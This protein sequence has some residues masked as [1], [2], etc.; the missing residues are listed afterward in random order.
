[1]DLVLKIPSGQGLGARSEYGKR[2]SDGPSDVPAKCR[3]REQCQQSGNRNDDEEALASLLGIFGGL[4]PLLKRLLVDSPHQRRT[5]FD[6]GGDLDRC[7]EL[8]G[9]PFPP[10]R[11]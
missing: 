5:E 10:R 4:A 1:M 3:G 2:T 7:P 8:N 9:V 11:Q 6:Q